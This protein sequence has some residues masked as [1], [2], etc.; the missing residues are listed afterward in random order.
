MGASCCADNLRNTEF[1]E[2][3]GEN[4]GEFKDLVPERQIRN[5]SN[6]SFQIQKKERPAI[7]EGNVSN[8]TKDLKKFKKF[9]TIGT[10]NMISSEMLTFENQASKKN[11][12]PAVGSIS[13]KTVKVGC[14]MNKKLSMLFKPSERDNKILRKHITN[15]MLSK[16]RYKVNII[17][18][19]N[20]RTL[21]KQRTTELQEVEAKKEDR[22][23]EN[24]RKIE[25]M[26]SNLSNKLSSPKAQ[27]GQARQSDQE[28]DKDL[29]IRRSRCK[30]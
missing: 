21:E 17:R 8:L 12:Q 16:E 3:A 18:C 14:L 2:S 1:Q 24:I 25:F 5:I 29:D 7:L 19:N 20:S 13:S 23:L 26:Q 11:V 6:S 28:D 27:A 10:S 9:N 15:L 30:L 4:K 22:Q